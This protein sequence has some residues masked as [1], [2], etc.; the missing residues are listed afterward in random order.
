MISTNMTP[1]PPTKKMLPARVRNPSAKARA[2]EDALDTDEDAPATKKGKKVAAKH[3]KKKVP[4]LEES[5]DEGV[6]AKKEDNV[7]G[8]DD[9]IDKVEVE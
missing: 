3:S 2:A 1:N 7:N 6:P 8:E 5:S 4:T 9:N